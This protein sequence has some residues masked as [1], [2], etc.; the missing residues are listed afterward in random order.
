MAVA[1]FLW[2]L[3]RGVFFL[4]FGIALG[5]AIGGGFAAIGELLR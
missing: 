2:D 3:I 4:A 1:R 5:M